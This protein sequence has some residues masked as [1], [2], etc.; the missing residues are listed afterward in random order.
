LR[1]IKRKC[2]N[3]DFNCPFI[4]ICDNVMT[5]KMRFHACDDYRILFF[6]DKPFEPHRLDYA[7]G[8]FFTKFFEKWEV[9]HTPARDENYKYFKRFLQFVRLLATMMSDRPIERAW[10]K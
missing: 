5:T 2:D 8:A 7:Y 4:E 9:E 1:E 6:Q 3:I 10:W